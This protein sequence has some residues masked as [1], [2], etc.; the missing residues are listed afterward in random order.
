MGLIRFRSRYR[1]RICVLRFISPH[2][3]YTLIMKYESFDFFFNNISQEILPCDHS[4]DRVVVI[5]D[6]QMPKSQISKQI[7]GPLQRETERN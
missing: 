1:D 2:F 5:Y 4:S 7:V 3:H 6:N